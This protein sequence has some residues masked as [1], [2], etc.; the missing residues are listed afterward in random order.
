MHTNTTGGPHDRPHTANA[1][2]AGRE[3]EQP[4]P[5]EELL[6]EAERVTEMYE[7]TAN[8]LTKDVLGKEPYADAE[9]AGRYTSYAAAMRVMTD[10]LKARAQELLRDMGA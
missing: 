4:D 10:S 7:E 9:V 5:M 1:E 6:K 2:P 8:R 3:Q